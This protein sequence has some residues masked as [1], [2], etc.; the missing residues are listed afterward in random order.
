MVLAPQ[1]Q[2][3]CLRVFPSMSFYVGHIRY[4]WVQ[5]NDVNTI[6]LSRTDCLFKVTTNFVQWKVWLNVVSCFPRKNSNTTLNILAYVD[7][8]ASEPQSTAHQIVETMHIEGCSWTSG[9]DVLIPRGMSHDIVSAA[10]LYPFQL[11]D[12]AGSWCLD[13]R[14]T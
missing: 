11:I 10:E 1:I 12:P 4:N 13:M 8:I 6:T 3:L 5:I 9:E 14:W 2:I 7:F